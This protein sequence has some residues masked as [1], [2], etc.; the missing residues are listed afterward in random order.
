VGGVLVCV[1]VGYG[2]FYL[3][4]RHAYVRATLTD[5][6][7]LVAD[8]V[9]AARRGG[10]APDAVGALLD[11]LAATTGAREVSVRGPGGA[12]LLAWRAAGSGPPGVP[13][14]TR[15]QA[16]PSGDVVQVRVAFTA[17]EAERF[18]S[19]NVDVWVVALVTLALLFI[20][21]R[22]SR[23]NV[24]E[25]LAGLTRQVERFARGDLAARAPDGAPGEIGLLAGRFNALAETVARQTEELV[26]EREYE[27]NIVQ[28]ITSGVVGLDAE[29]RVTTWNG[30][31]ARR[32]GVPAEAAA[33]RPVEDLCPEVFDP[34]VATAVR[35]LL[36]GARERF[37]LVG[38]SHPT[39]HAGDHVMDVRGR[40]LLDGAGHTYG[41]VLAV[42]D[43][44]EQV[45]L[46][47]Q[48]R[49]AEKLAT[50]G[51]LAAGLAHE[52]GT[53][54]NVISGRAEFVLKKLPEGDDLRRHLTRI[55]AQIDRISGI[56]SQMLVFARKRPP[57]K[58]R[59]EVAELVDTVVDLVA[60]P[61]D[62]A[63]IALETDI[64]KDLWL[65]ADPDQVQQVVINILINGIQAMGSGGTF[66]VRATT[67]CLPSRGYATYVGLSVA[68]TGPGMPPDVRDHIFDPFFTTKEPGKGTGMGLP[69][70]QGIVSAHGGWIEVESAPG[71]GS[72]FTVY[73]PQSTSDAD[74]D[75]PAP[76]A[77]GAP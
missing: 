60:H 22:L 29:A 54:L 7:R 9:A 43:R 10:L 28:N 48:L 61:L 37:D 56:V 23:T 26:K 66:R 45:A 30:A 14:L 42:D 76:G 36:A 32:Y 69:V 13:E 53:P 24:A 4:V 3:V 71:A 19:R 39:A 63:G 57:R 51:Q 41:V 47:A 38:L 70:A 50:I 21:H 77:E 18:S 6:A 44:T 2:V 75:A 11:D 15:E 20:V 59:L 72:C 52:I 64:P 17:R 8:V 33:G 67:L 58:A 34:A 12:P 65:D 1:A 55:V 40:A 74:T 73:L 46:T 5:N 16:A 35:E 27:R 62:R 31:M 68:D 49:H 25:P